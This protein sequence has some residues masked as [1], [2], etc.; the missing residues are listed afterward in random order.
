MSMELARQTSAQAW[1]KDSTKH[2]EM[3][4]AL[5][6]AFAEILEDVWSKPWLGNATTNEM[7]TELKTRAEIHGWGTWTYRTIDGDKT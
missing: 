4:S 1:C 5:A 2:I 6:E 3:N 7:L